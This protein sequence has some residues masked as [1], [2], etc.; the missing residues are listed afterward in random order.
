MLNFYVIRVD[1]LLVLIGLAL[2]PHDVL[3]ILNYSFAFHIKMSFA[4]DTPFCTHGSRVHK[5]ADSTHVSMH[6]QIMTQNV[7]FLTF[8]YQNSV[9]HIAKPPSLR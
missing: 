6:C 8:L 3:K 9:F 5:N 4:R 1:F 2:W 7:M